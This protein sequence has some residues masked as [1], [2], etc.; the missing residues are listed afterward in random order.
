MSRVTDSRAAALCCSSIWHRQ[1]QRDNSIDPRRCVAGAAAPDV[2]AVPFPDW[3]VDIQQADGTR[4]L[5][6]TRLEGR[7]ARPWLVRQGGPRNT[8]PRR[9]RRRQAM[10]RTDPKE[11]NNSQIFVKKKGKSSST[12]TSCAINHVPEDDGAAG[13]AL[14]FCSTPA[15]RPWLLHAGGAGHGRHSG[16]LE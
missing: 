2:G 4:S 5:V 15:A 11:G 10:K 1:L 7:E 13:A 6:A 16:C 14:P 8:G 12:L 3:P 9:H